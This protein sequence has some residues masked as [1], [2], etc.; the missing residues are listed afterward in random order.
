MVAAAGSSPFDAL[1]KRNGGTYALIDGK[2]H[3]RGLYWLL[4]HVVHPKTY[5]GESDGNAK[6]AAVAK[7]IQVIRRGDPPE[8]PPIPVENVVPFLTD[9]TEAQ[10]RYLKRVLSEGVPKVVQK[11]FLRDPST[12]LSDLAEGEEE[13]PPWSPPKPLKQHLEEVPPPQKPAAAPAEPEAP[14]DEPRTPAALKERI[15]W[16]HQWIE[17]CFVRKNVQGIW[18]AQANLDTGFLTESEGFVQAFVLLV[19]KKESHP[20]A[21]DALSD[22]MKLWKYRCNGKQSMIVWNYV[23]VLE[24]LLVECNISLNLPPDMAAASEELRGIMGHSRTQPV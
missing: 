18:Y 22:K 13:L 10:T 24:R 21:Y 4:Q 6:D 14:I 23:Q 3:E 15:E 20:K 2:Q 12:W 7:L 9:L 8:C 16:I 11:P 19:V 5:E 17:L 1:I